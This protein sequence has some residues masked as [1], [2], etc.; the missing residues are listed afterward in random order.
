MSSQ[1]L[2]PPTRSGISEFT[3]PGTDLKCQTS[4][5]IWGDLESPSEALPP[6]ICLHGGPGCPS[7][8]IAVFARLHE[9]HGITTILYDQIGCGDSTH[10]PK[11]KGDESFWT[12][13]LFIAELN[14]L[15]ASLDMKEY[16]VFG[17]SWG[18]MLAGEFALTQPAGLKKL[19]LCSGPAC[20]AVRVACTERQKA[21]LPGDIPAILKKFEEAGDMSNPEYQKAMQVFYARHL[22][23]VNPMPTELGQALKLMR[24]DDTVYAT[25]YG[26]SP[27]KMTGP[28]KDFDLREKLY[29][30]TEATVPGGVML[31]NGKYDTAQ[32]EV[33]MPFFTNIRA[34]VKWVRFADSSHTS[35]WE[36][37]EEFFSVLAGF[38][39]A[40]S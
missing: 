32:D 23:R 30:I 35:F 10:L 36:E 1:P 11:T 16:S 9:V 40:T 2:P 34:R 17:H 8:S 15:I 19:I 4:Y 39:E 26:T 31:V 27:L 38:L 7:Q 6:L 37:T 14:N 12:V 20:I 18:A 33:I 24:E 21:A 25:L 13:E 28:M 29:R 3:P 22:C 5:R